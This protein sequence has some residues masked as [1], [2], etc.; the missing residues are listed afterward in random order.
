MRIKNGY[1][2]LLFYLVILVSALIAYNI[3]NG[4][5]TDGVDSPDFSAKRV[6]EDIRV[7]SMTPH[8][9]EHPKERKVV[10]NYLAGRL[11]QLGGEV[12]IFEYDSIECKLGGWIN[13]ANIY[14]K[15]DPP[16]ETDSTRYILM[17]AHYD[18]RFR[19]NVLGRR[20]YSLGAA[21]DGYGVG[22][23]LESL[24]LALGYKQNWKQGI[25]VLFTDAEEHNLD[26]MY[27]MATEDS[28]ILDN[29][30]FVIN[31]EARGV[32]G[33]ALL[34][35]TGR[36][37]RNVM[38]L[39][40]EAEDP[41]AYSLTTFIYS[42]LPND[43]DFSIVKDSIPGFNFAVIDNL[44][45]YHTERD[46]FSNIS[47]E[48]IEHYGSQ[49][50]PVLHRYITDSKY[51]LNNSLESDEE[52]IFFT[53]PLLGL[54]LFS[55]SGYLWVNIVI[56]IISLLA[57]HKVIIHRGIKACGVFKMVLYATALA[58]GAL[59]VGE[60]VA[61]LAAY[62]NGERFSLSSVKYVE[63][64]YAIIIGSLVAMYLLVVFL[65]KRLCNIRETFLA[66]M[67]AGVV[68]LFLPISLLFYI[69]TGEN[70]FILIPLII[71]ALP[72][73]IPY[74]GI[75]RVICICGI[76]IISLLGFSFLYCLITAL[77]IGSLGIMLFLATLYI[78]VA[79]VLYLHFI[80]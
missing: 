56:M 15:F 47:L 57:L 53:L 26:G 30:D 63:Y 58:L 6:A 4:A 45:Y 11:E 24:K 61:W 44:K 9:I 34:F 68:L 76:L 65:F 72:P 7:I 78:I 5:G 54:F 80:S 42:I 32:K 19:Q 64:D 10:G 12:Q 43:T 69:L 60:A 25:K 66:E 38:E 2:A 79:R 3:G 31:V 20:Q 59:I 36:G 55:K 22:V 52:S 40:R 46:N 28:H 51:S 21:D 16:Q 37:N 62:I 71:A 77:T 49:I 70:F 18:S 33:P 48:S 50:V 8:S 14:S 75:R 35:E 67:S 13:I 39:Y 41:Y 27:K 23:I 17:V 29:V 73:L 74:A 1:K